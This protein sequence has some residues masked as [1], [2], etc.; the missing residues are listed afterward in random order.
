M[1]MTEESSGQKAER[2]SA[3]KTRLIVADFIVSFLFL[4]GFQCFLSKRT[5]LFSAGLTDNFYLQCLMFSGL[6]LFLS[7][8][9]GLPVHFVSSFIVEKKFCLS[10]QDLRGWAVDEMKSLA[11]SF[12]FFVFCVEAFYLI[13]RVFPGH[14][15]LV[16]SFGWIFFTVILTKI[17]PVLLIPVFFKYSSLSDGALKEKVLV[18]A[19]KAKID[20]LDVCQIDFSRKT[21]KANAALTGLGGTRRVI[22]T[23]T[24]LGEFSPGEIEAV[25]AHEFG[26]FKLRHIWQLLFFSGVFTILGFFVLSKVIGWV[27]SISGA[28]SVSDLYLFPI[29]MLL[30]FISGIMLLPV[31]NYFSRI[32]ER[33]ADL[34]ALELTNNPENFIAM[35][36]KLGEKNLADMSPSKIKKIFLF[37][38]PPI[39]E[40]INM[41]KKFTPKDPNQT[42]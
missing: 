34:F 9:V 42:T 3:I 12:V 23:D 7:Y 11:I 21:K 28:S 13:L 22:L 29:M 16:A 17:F 2:Y 25:V 36:R 40:R 24:L 10:T 1:D 18:M 5:A 31:Q 6:L 41:A 32:L 35:M 15:W 33:D 38:H 26:H 4:V 20:L 27:V 14:W 39:F 19:K 37:N 30:M 8:V